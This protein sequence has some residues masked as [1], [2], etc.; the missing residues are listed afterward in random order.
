MSWE[1]GSLIIAGTS[2]FFMVLA[3]GGYRNMVKDL[4]KQVDTMKTNP[5]RQDYDQCRDHFCK[6]LETIFGLLAEMDSKREKARQVRDNQLNDIL[7]KI[8]DI[9]SE[10]GE[11][12]GNMKGIT[13]QMGSIQKRMDTRKE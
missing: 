9:L 6:Q 12:R 7:D 13:S 3:V 1:W 8:G 5:T 10:I 2:L 11:L 4:H